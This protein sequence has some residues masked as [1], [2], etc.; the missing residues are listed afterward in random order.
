MKEARAVGP[1]LGILLR[2]LIYQDSGKLDLQGT[3]IPAYTLN[4][5]LGYI[6]FIGPFLI[7]GEIGGL[8][9]LTY[10]IKGTR[11]DPKVSINPLSALAPGFLR[12]IIEG[13]DAPLVDSLDPN[14]PLKLPKFPND[15]GR[16]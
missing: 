11:D 5:A 2:G 4:S 15:I 6:P 13:F 3:I 12:R 14:K 8:F 10:R 1:S 16:N 7:G 9:A